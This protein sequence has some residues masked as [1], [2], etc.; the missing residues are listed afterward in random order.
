MLYSN[1]KSDGSERVLYDNADYPA[2][3]QKG[4]LSSYPNYT[5]QS[6]WHDDMEFILII[7][8]HM[9]Y[10]INGEIILLKENEG[11]FV[12]ARQLHFGYSEDKSECVF[13]CVL[14]HPILL[15]LSQNIEQRYVVPIISNNE[16]MF[17]H[18]KE[19]CEWEKN[20]LLSVRKI[21]DYKNDKIS[22]LKIQREFFNIWIEL[23]ENV[24]S[25][26]QEI[27]SNNHYLTILKTM[28]S[29]INRNYKE[30]INLEDIAGAGNVGKTNCCALFK[31]YVNK[32]PNEYLTEL[33]LR[34]SI[35]LL[36]KTDMT[37]LEI[38]YETGFSGASYFTEVF[39]K[40]FG[41]TPSMYRQHHLHTKDFNLL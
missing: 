29:Y 3:V 20:I 35:E 23:C 36:Q 14:L 21:Y 30:K 34:K 10:N 6:H 37:I 18:L 19:C 2:Y 39:H 32:T 31:Q 8:G 28:I 26:K 4:F 25:I 38:C 22:E 41:C 16:I 40:Y 5:A 12:N 17:C 1:I 33:R 7:S 11:V 24:I 15:C 13:I 9:L 27:N